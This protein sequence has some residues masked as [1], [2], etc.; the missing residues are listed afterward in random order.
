MVVVQLVLLG[1][2][3]QSQSL[4]DVSGGEQCNGV[5]EC[6]KKSVRSLVQ[7]SMMSWTQ[8]GAVEEGMVQR[9]QRDVSW[10][11]KFQRKDHEVAALI[12][13]AQLN[14]MEI[15]TMVGAGVQAVTDAVLKF[16]AKPPQIHEGIQNLGKD[17]L[18]VFEPLVEEAFGEQYGQMESEWISFFD[19]LPEDVLPGIEENVNMF[20]DEGATQN[21]VWAIGD[22]LQMLHDLVITLPEA[23]A[24]EIAKYMD[25]VEDVVKA[26][27]DSWIDFEAATFEKSAAAAEALYQATQAAVEKLLPENI[28]ND[29]TYQIVTDALD[30]VMSLLS[31]HTYEYKETLQQSEVC[32]R[33]PKNNPN[34][35]SASICPEDYDFT[36]KYNKA[37]C[38]PRNH[39]NLDDSTEKKVDGAVAK[40]TY[41]E[42]AVWADCDVESE[43]TVFDSHY[44]FGPCETGWIPAGKKE[45][46]TKCKIECTGTFPHQASDMCGKFSHS[47]SSWWNNLV[48]TSI[49]AGWTLIE[50]AVGM[51]EEGVTVARMAK[52]IN[53]LATF[54]QVF[55]RPQCE[56]VM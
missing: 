45:K 28:T 41:G 26:L 27:G 32:V 17:L 40:K 53:G 12:K 50:E 2:V 30:E 5:Q 56:N 31:K 49:A 1:L 39:S 52:T 10:K 46:P 3:C 19:S 18:Q 20:L 14:P 23:T 6:R 21:L 51:N 8:M 22:S 36:M 25:A 29:E 54:G 9:A 43:H 48:F 47:V 38:T 42:G 24:A 34:K 44:C 35:V 16:V 11:H 15:A 37:G 7:N 33:T 55:A 13:R 4:E